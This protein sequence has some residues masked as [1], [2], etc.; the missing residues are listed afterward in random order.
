MRKFYIFTKINKETLKFILS[1]LFAF[2]LTTGIFCQGKKNLPKNDAK[3]AFEAN[4][5]SGRI[6]RHNEKFLPSVTQQS[7]GFEV[8]ASYKTFGDKNWQRALN[9][10]EIGIGY[11]QT[12]FGDKEIFGS[13]YGLLPFVKF[14]IVRSK[15]VDF[16][17]KL[18]AGVSY[19]SKSYHPVSNPLNNVIG[20]KINS[21]IQFRMGLD[22]ALYPEVD[23]VLAGTLTHYSNSSTQAPNLGINLPTVNIG[24][25]YKPKEFTK[26]YN[27]EKNLDEFRRKNEYILRL[28]LGIKDKVARGAKYPVY[29]GAIQ[30][31][32]YFGYANKLIAGVSFSFD[33]Y[34]YDFIK[35]QEIG[36][37]DELIADASGFSVYGGYEMMVGKVGINFLVG[38]YLYG[39]VKNDTPL[40]AKPGIT[41]YFT[42]FGKHKH[43]PFVGVNIKTH[44]FEA[45]YA[46]MHFG[47][48]F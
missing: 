41:Y 18:G 23:L 8:N 29:S 47:I 33:Q 21:I 34:E 43:K 35:I 9:Y 40:W 19:I 31:A 39:K 2:S 27:T 48:A 22:F 4:L 42:E 26:E 16:Y 6:L 25:V 44:Y 20:S 11:I 3:I 36:E 45:Q 5:S 17:A 46:E 10:P 38:T 32:R 24:V 28:S 12:H 37:E 7:Y 1:I 30:Y 15:P 13:A 14:N